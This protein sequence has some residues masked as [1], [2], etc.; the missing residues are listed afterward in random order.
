MS[1]RN[2]TAN[3]FEV[4]VAEWDYLDGIHAEEH[5]SYFAIEEGIHDI[6]GLVMEAGKT[7]L[8]Q[9]TQRVE[10]EYPFGVM[11]IILA[12]VEHHLSSAI[13]TVQIQE[14]TLSGFSARMAAQEAG[15]GQSLLLNRVVH[16]VSVMPG[17]SASSTLEAGL[18][19]SEYNHV[20]TPLYTASS[21]PGDHLFAHIQNQQG[22]QAC[23]LRQIKMD[24]QQDPA[25]IMVQEEQSNDE[26]MKH[27]HEAL[28]Y[29]KVSHF[30]E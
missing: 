24:E 19:A 18:T 21:K 7:S 22:Y 1:I 6:D 29:L 11:P 14:T 16:Y 28:G 4:R 20:A 23:S 8:T 5:F 27:K 2:I 15:L 13:A 26:E 9:E 10:L 3:G 12:T 17:L 25:L 30:N